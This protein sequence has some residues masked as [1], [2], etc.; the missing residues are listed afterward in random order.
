MKLLIKHKLA[1]MLD[2]GHL[3]I[4]IE[5]IHSALK[6]ASLKVGCCRSLDTSTTVILST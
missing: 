4:R 5:Q 6:V 3:Q 2:H 1:G